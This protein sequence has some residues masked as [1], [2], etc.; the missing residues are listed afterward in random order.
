MLV[1]AGPDYRGPRSQADSC[2]QARRWLHPPN[3]VDGVL[4]YV[5][6]VDSRYG[7]ARAAGAAILTEPAD[8]PP[9]GL[10]KAGD[11]EGHRWMF[12]QAPH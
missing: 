6:D 3:V 10:Y 11:L 12:M 1:C 5:D 7:R 2:E 8:E 9:G 4:V